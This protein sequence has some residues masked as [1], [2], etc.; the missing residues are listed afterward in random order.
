[1][2]EQKQQEQQ[3]CEAQCTQYVEAVLLLRLLLFSMP[4]NLLL[5]SVLQE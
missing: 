2:Q 3:G 5:L 4:R 1:M